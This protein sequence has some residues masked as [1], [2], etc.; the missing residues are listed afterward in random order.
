LTRL[1]D[2]D[3]SGPVSVMKPVSFKR[4]H[5][6]PEVNLELLTG[7]GGIALSWVEQRRLYGIS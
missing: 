3:G 7:T 1:V 5:C 6:P 4:H 2:K